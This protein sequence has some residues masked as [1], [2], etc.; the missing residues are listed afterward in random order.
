[1]PRQL[2]RQAHAS[3]SIPQPVLASQNVNMYQFVRGLRWGIFTGSPQL[4]EPIVNCFYQQGGQHAFSLVSLSNTNVCYAVPKGWNIMQGNE[5]DTMNIVMWQEKD[6]IVR[7]RPL[8]DDDQI[9]QP[10]LHNYKTDE[11]TACG[12]DPQSNQL[13]VGHKSGKITVYQ[14]ISVAPDKFNKNRF[15]QHSMS[16]TKM[17]YN[18]AFRKV[19]SKGKF[20]KSFLS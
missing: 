20:F 4:P 14:C 8:S 6:G 9:A 18:S 12:T 2:M 16:F 10:L 17:S 5:P 15:V 7:I 11:I 3:A 13:W 19:S 1:M